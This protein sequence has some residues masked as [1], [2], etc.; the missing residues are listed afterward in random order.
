MACSN[1]RKTERGNPPE[2]ASSSPPGK[3][4]AAQDPPR[5]AFEQDV[6]P[7]I[8]WNLPSCDRASP[9]PN[10]AGLDLARA[11][12]RFGTPVSQESFRLGERVDEFHVALRNTYPMTDPQ[13]AYVQLQELTWAE[14]ECRLTIWF[15]LR[16]GVWQSFENLHWPQGAEF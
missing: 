5:E 9:L 4:P 1:I 3:P 13:N 12:S 2:A 7:D 16:E 6:A 14:G 10:L 8:G 11:K 15:H